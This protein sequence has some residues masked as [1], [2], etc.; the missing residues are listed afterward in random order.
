MG[1]FVGW[2]VGFEAR[3]FYLV[4]EGL[5]LYIDQVGLKQKSTCLCL[6]SAGIKDV[7]RHVWSLR[8]VFN[9]FKEEFK[10]SNQK[11]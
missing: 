8:L 11:L 1:W 9:T 6:F 7:H 10:L 3:S 5:E 2:L 4:L